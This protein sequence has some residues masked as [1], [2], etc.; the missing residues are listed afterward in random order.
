MNL[1]PRSRQLIVSFLRIA[2]LPL[3]VLAWASFTN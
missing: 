2:S 1:R 3:A